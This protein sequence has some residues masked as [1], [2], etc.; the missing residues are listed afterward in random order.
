[1]TI[2]KSQVALIHPTIKSEMDLLDRSVAMAEAAFDA[3][4]TG[5]A[6]A[7]NCN[8][9]LGAGR[10]LQGAARQRLTQR[11]AAGRLIL[12]EARIVGGEAADVT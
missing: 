12:L 2:S 5:A 11:L 3:I 10:V 4:T 9:M 7:K 6:E 8:V 1:M